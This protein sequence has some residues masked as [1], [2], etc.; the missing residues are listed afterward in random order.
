LNAVTCQLCGSGDAFLLYELDEYKILKCP[1]CHL[2]FTEPLNIDPVE[3]YSADYF[4][5]F[6]SKFFSSC[7]EDYVSYERDPRLAA[8]EQ[9]LELISSYKKAGRILDVGCATG[10]FLDMSRN[11]GWEPHGVDISEY[12]SDYAREKFGIRVETK[13]LQ[14]VDFPARYFDVITMWDTIEHLSNPCQALDESFKI[15]KDDGLVF[16]QTVDEDSLMPRIAHLMYRLSG[17][18]L[19]KPVRLVHP[20]HHVT[21]FSKSTLVQMLERSGF[22]VVYLRKSEIPLQSLRWGRGTK[23]IIGVMYA[24]AK[25]LNMQYEI[26]VLARKREQ[27]DNMRG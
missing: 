8:F 7:H 4:E 26:K 9:G 6:Q 10:V 20:I 3:L 13:E 27:G 14:E 16:I 21:H 1:C 25:L 24:F 17:G 2:V 22:E 15:L 23:I 18:K 5:D 11:R 19:K 12:A